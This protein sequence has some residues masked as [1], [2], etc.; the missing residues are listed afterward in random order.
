MTQ[1]YPFYPLCYNQYNYWI[2]VTF[3]FLFHCSNSGHWQPFQVIAMPPSCLICQN[4]LTFWHLKVFHAHPSIGT[5]HFSKEFWF[6]LLENYTRLSEHCESLIAA[7]IPMPPTLVSS[8]LFPSK[9]NKL[10]MTVLETYVCPWHNNGHRATPYSRKNADFR[11][12]RQLISWRS[13]FESSLDRK[14]IVS[15]RNYK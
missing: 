15:K 10:K 8:L 7:P 11:S 14:G 13:D 1:G 9:K 4:F 3:F 5:N 6:I 2:Y 12:G